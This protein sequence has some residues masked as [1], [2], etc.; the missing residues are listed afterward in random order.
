MK[1]LLCTTLSYWKIAKICAMQGAYLRFI[2]RIMS[3]IELGRVCMG[4]ENPTTLFY[5]ERSL[6]VRCLNGLIMHAYAL[7]I[8]TQMCPNIAARA[9]YRSRCFLNETMAL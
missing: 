1:M 5:C 2:N 6:Y 9:R 4:D 7:V 8:Q 3:T